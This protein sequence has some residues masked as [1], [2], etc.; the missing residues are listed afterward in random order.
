MCKQ[1]SDIHMWFQQWKH[2]ESF[3]RHP[4]WAPKETF[5]QTISRAGGVSPHSNNLA[6]LDC[7]P[8][9]LH[10]FTSRWPCM[11]LETVTANHL[12]FK[13]KMISRMNRWLNFKVYS[14]NR[15]FLTIPMR[16][17]NTV[18]LTPRTWRNH[19]SNTVLPDRKFD[20]P[21]VLAAY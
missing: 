15:D 16:E 10:S 1:N 14:R 8:L 19:P 9:F 18:Y 21:P 11:Q 2:V 6:L 13:I 7:F 20:P 17:W 4:L 3:V 12:C 5:S